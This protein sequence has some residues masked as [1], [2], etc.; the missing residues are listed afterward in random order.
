M[1]T[2]PCMRLRWEHMHFNTAAATTTLIAFT[3]SLIRPTLRNS[4]SRACSVPLPSVLS[5][6]FSNSPEANTANPWPPSSIFVSMHLTAGSFRPLRPA[7]E[8]AQSPR[9][10]AHLASWACPQRGCCVFPI[11]NSCFSV[12]VITLFLKH[13]LPHIWFSPPSLI[14][15]NST[16][17]FVDGLSGSSLLSIYYHLLAYA[18]VSLEAISPL[19][20][21]DWKWITEEVDAPDLPWFPCLNKWKWVWLH[22]HIFPPWL[23]SPLCFPSSSMSLKSQVKATN[24]TWP[25]VASWA[26]GGRAVS[27]RMVKKERE[28][29]EGREAINYKVDTS[30]RGLKSNHLPQG[31]GK[32]QIH[33][34]NIKTQWQEGK[35]AIWPG[36]CVFGTGGWFLEH[37]KHILHKR[38]R[39]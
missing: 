1:E 14:D 32:Q 9:T 24:E 34:S 29:S 2:S 39:M 25:R 18:S 6:A 36:V 5:Q 3:L 28:W 10:H 37:K 12:A 13:P 35:C 38:P 20:I 8:C 19:L 16:C 27:R 17:L 11:H 22:Y 26:M 33:G 30:S 23:Q 15:C 7:R 21:K 4:E 31:I